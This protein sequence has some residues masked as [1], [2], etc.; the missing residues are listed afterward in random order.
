MLSLFWS[1]LTRDTLS[2]LVLS[3]SLSLCLSLIVCSP[4]PAA[5]LFFLFAWCYFLC[6][7]QQNTRGWLRFLEICFFLTPLRTSLV[8]LCVPLFPTYLANSLSIY[9]CIRISFYFSNCVILFHCRYF[10]RVKLRH[11]VH[12]YFIL[13]YFSLVAHLLHARSYFCSLGLFWSPWDVQPSGIFALI[14]NSLKRCSPSL[15]PSSQSCFMSVYHLSAPGIL[16]SYA[17][18]LIVM[19]SVSLKYFGGIY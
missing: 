17:V 10:D 3:H 8:V 16:S 6:W 9:F 5:C 2:A 12:S 13:C 4:T 18:C 1:S 19:L 7:T 14:N 11:P 15:H